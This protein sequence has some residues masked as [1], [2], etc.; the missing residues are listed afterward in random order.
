MVQILILWCFAVLT[1]NYFFFWIFKW[2][3]KTLKFFNLD[4]HPKSFE[5]LLKNLEKLLHILKN[6]TKFWKTS[7][8]F[9]KLL[10]ILKKNSTFWKKSPKNWKISTFLHLTWITRTKKGLAAT[11]TNT[12]IYLFCSIHEGDTPIPHIWKNILSVY[13]VFQ[14]KLR[15]Y[16]FPKNLIKK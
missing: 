1:I 11:R 6:L 2:G 14:V 9:K 12:Q 15:I 5:Y 16:Y 4:A 3:V 8:H 13:F 10:H 7:P